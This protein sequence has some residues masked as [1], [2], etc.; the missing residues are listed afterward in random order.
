MQLPKWRTTPSGRPPVTVAT[1]AHVDAK[2]AHDRLLHREIFVKL[3][4]DAR[5]AH[6]PRTVRTL[7][8]QR[9]VV[10]F[11]DARGPAAI[12]ARAIRRT[13]FATWSAR[14]LR[15][16]PTRE[17]RGLTVHCPPRGL[18]FVFQF[19]VFATQPLSLGF[20]AP[21]ILAQPV[22][23]PRLIVDDLLR[24]PGAWI[25]R[26]PLHAPVM[27]EPRSKYKYGILDSQH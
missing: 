16:D 7:R 13:R 25:V 24:V 12:G 2:V 6:L 14:R 21:Q 23:L 5:P 1:R 9:H 4:R 15:R 19:F 22:D 18:E 17:R 26:T 10:G 27:P 20:R 8:G 11:I 3:R